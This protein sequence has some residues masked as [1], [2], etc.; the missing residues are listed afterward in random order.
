M[1]SFSYLLSLLLALY[2]DAALCQDGNARARYTIPKEQNVVVRCNVKECKDRPFSLGR[3]AWATVTIDKDTASLVHLNY[4]LS[5]DVDTLDYVIR[6]RNR[7]YISFRNDS[8]TWGA[9]AIPVRYRRGYTG[10]LGNAIGSDVSASF[11]ANVYFGRTF[12]RAGYRYE[13]YSANTFQSR[14]NVSIAGLFGLSAPEI[15]PSST[16][17]AGADSLRTKRLLLVASPGLG[18]MTNIRGVDL[19]VFLGVDHGI[20]DGA[21]KW[22]Y[23][24]KPWL[25]LGVGFQLFKLK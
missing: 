9:L 21:A 7:E 14:W 4:W 16:Q 23:S 18:M 6:L 25:G 24:N 12:G 19:G 2:A 8:W 5:P 10:R 20:T 1:R 3:D 15:G 22:D 17:S 13:K 11:N